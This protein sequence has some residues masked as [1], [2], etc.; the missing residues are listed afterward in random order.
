[1]WTCLVPSA[2]GMPATVNIPESGLRPVAVTDPLGRFREKEIGSTKRYLLRQVA[3]WY[4]TQNAQDDLVS[5]GQSQVS[6][7][8]HQ[9]SVVHKVAANYPHRF[10]LCD[11]VGLGKTIE[12]GMALKELRA[13]GGVERV[14]AIVPPNL[15]RQW[16]FELKTKFNE[17]FSVLNTATVNSMRADGY[18]GN[19]FANP[20][21]PNILCS[22]RWV[23][24]K[25]WGIP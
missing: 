23:S 13:R 20:E 2:S 18:A 25:N 7:Q 10:M 22:S 6:V 17:T 14:L 4:R 11:E 24:G 12:A 16:Q 19:P 3:Q 8:P 9:V 21:Y 5:L 15:V 1:M